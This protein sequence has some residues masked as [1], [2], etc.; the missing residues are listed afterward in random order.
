MPA[1]DPVIRGSQL[2]RRP[3]RRRAGA[4]RGLAAVEAAFVMPF[5]VMLMLGVWEVGRMVEVNQILTNAVREGARVAAGGTTNNIPVT[6]SM[7]QAQVQNYMT[8]AGLPSAAVTGSTV[9][10]TNL[11]SNT[12]TDPSDASPLDQYQVAV[13]IPSGSAFNSLRWALTSSITGMTSL[14]VSTK[15]YSANDSK[16]T[17]STTLPY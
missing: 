14:T 4:R 13:T 10:L 2:S 7:V 11:S 9:T 12:W 8:A 3:A 15:W 6:V 1:V 5:L 17:V 16:L